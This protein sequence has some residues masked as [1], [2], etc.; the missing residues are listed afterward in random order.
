MTDIYPYNPRSVRKTH[1]ALKEPELDG[2]LTSYFGIPTAVMSSARAGIY[3]IIKQLGLVRTDHI[4]V[5]DFLCRS[6]L[7]ILNLQ[8]FG[9]QQADNRTKAIFAL[10]QWGYPQRMDLIMPE[11]KKHGWSVIE[12]CVHSFGSTYQGKMIGTFGDAA[13]VSFPKMFP[14]YT[15]GAVLSKRQDIIDSIRNLRL[16]PRSFWHRLFDWFSTYESRQKYLK[17]DKIFLSNAVYIKSIHFPRITKVATRRFPENIDELKSA[18]ARR[19]EIFHAL[20]KNLSKEYYPPELD[21]ESDVVPLCVPIFLP[22]SKLLAA[23][24]MLRAK[25]IQAEILHFD[26]NR[27]VLNPNYKKCLALPCHQEVTD[28]ELKSMCDVIARV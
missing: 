26:V 12:D 10:H 27:N 22:E 1:S 18:V 13:I 4:L 25:N 8:G 21:A 3:Q 17:R 9:I 15:G 19:K 14:T 5:P 7:Y 24:E 6:V 11:A 16:E 2:L 23:Q 20:K 28:E